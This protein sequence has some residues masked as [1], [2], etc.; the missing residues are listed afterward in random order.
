MAGLRDDVLRIEKGGEGESGEVLKKLGDAFVIGAAVGALFGVAS[1]LTKEES[2]I[3]AGGFL[4]SQLRDAVSL[5]GGLGF[6]S[7]LVRGL[8]VGGHV[9][10]L[11]HEFGVLFKDSLRQIEGVRCL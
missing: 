4:T 9:N 8:C 6:V 2:A 7:A 3:R 10:W 11:D 1:F 5:V